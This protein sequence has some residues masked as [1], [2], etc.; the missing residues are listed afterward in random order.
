MPRLSNKEILARGAI[1][2]LDCIQELVLEASNG[3]SGT[4]DYRAVFFRNELDVLR[5]IRILK[6]ANKPCPFYIKHNFPSWGYES[7]GL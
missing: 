2:N 1:S 6:E 3:A 7:K 5:W 4:R